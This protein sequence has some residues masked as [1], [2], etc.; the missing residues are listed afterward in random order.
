MNMN[1]KADTLSFGSTLRQIREKRGYTQAQLADLSGMSRRMIGH[2][3]TL[4]RRP[5]VDKVKRLADTLGVSVNELMDS[6]LP[7]KQQ[8]EKEKATY[9]IMKRAREIEKLP[10]RDKDMVFSLIN[11]LVQKNKL[12][13]KK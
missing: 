13:E 4:V 2:Y 9:S 3:E 11:T 6:P 10:K 5:S 12:K 8:M 7:S 1:V